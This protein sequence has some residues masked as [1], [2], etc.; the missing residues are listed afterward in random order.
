MRKSPITKS[1]FLAKRTVI[2][3]QAFTNELPPLKKRQ[4]NRR[5]VTLPS[6]K[7]L[8]ILPCEP[9][10][11]LITQVEL[12]PKPLILP[13]KKSIS[14]RSYGILTSSLKTRFKNIDINSKKIPQDDFL[15]FLK[16]KIPT[17][18]FVREK[19]LCKKK[20]KLLKDVVTIFEEDQEQYCV[21]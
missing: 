18:D 21:E 12:S 5:S 9:P 7:I 11:S 13:L 10:K 19:N 15:T 6:C 1:S 8:E 17:F 4:N 20:E 2:R 3:S 14:S 16:E